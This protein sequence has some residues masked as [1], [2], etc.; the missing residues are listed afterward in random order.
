M[1]FIYIIA[2]TFGLL[3]SAC[4]L[5]GPY[6][7][8]RWQ[9]LVNSM[10]SVTFLILNLLLLAIANPDSG[11]NY[12]GIII[13]AVA[14]VVLSFSLWHVRKGTQAPIYE[15]IIFFAAYLILGA[16]GVRGW[17]DL[18]P[19]LGAVFFMLA[20]FQHNEQKTRFIYLFNTASWFTYHC[21]VGSSAA[22]GQ[23][24]S[25]CMYAIALYRYSKKGQKKDAT[26]V[27]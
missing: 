21:F 25:F 15:K 16:L 27:Q 24:A 2:Q 7:K 11:V 26:K 12:S 22:I 20:A 23:L 19:I 5:I 9:M 18:F 1:S 3:Q 4:C 17:V 13:N 8:H 14:L 10:V 6:F